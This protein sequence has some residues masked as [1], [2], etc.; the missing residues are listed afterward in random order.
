MKSLLIGVAILSVLRISCMFGNS[1][2]KCKSEEAFSIMLEPVECDKKSLAK[3]SKKF[4]VVENNRSLEKREKLD[5]STKNVFRKKEETDLDHEDYNCEFKKILEQVVKGE[6]GE[7]EE[8]GPSKLQKV[9]SQE[10]LKKHKSEKDLKKTLNNLMLGSNIKATH[11]D[12][13]DTEDNIPTN[14]QPKIPINKLSFFKE[15]TPNFKLIIKAPL[16]KPQDP[17]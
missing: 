6:E 7:E 11:K 1:L 2:K 5:I 17:K 9:R 4:P 3:K 8:L 16:K 15:Q 13:T 10:L 14:V 12:S